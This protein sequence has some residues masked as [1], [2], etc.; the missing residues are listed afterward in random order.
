MLL[1]KIDTCMKKF[2]GD[3]LRYQYE[4]GDFIPNQFP[5]H[6]TRQVEAAAILAIVRNEDPFIAR[7][8][9]AANEAREHIDGEIDVVDGSYGEPAPN[10]A[11][12]I[13]SLIDE[14]IAPFNAQSASRRSDK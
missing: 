8:V 6:L 13:A 5:A 12:S 4:T 10:R 14:A 9:E 2:R 11:M 1:E 3:R 7:L